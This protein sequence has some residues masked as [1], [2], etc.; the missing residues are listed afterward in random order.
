MKKTA[1]LTAYLFISLS[2]SATA[3]SPKRNV[4]KNSVLDYP[5]ILM[6]HPY[7]QLDSLTDSLWG[8]QVSTYAWKA[9]FQDN[10][11][12]YIVNALNR[13]QCKE[14]FV[15]PGNDQSPK[16]QDFL[17]MASSA[18]IAVARLLGENSYVEA[19]NGFPNLEA[20]ML[21]FKN[22]GFTAI[23][24]DIEPHALADYKQNIDLYTER[25][26]TLILLSSQWCAQEGIELSISIPM[27]TQ[28]STAALLALL[29]IKSYIM[30]Y[31]N[32]N[33]LS[34]L[35]RT[36]TLRDTLQGLYVWVVRAKDF[37]DLAHLQSAISVLNQNGVYELGIYDIKEM[38][39]R[40]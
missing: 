21:S 5:T 13:L 9:F 17:Q 6:E 23:H 4:A 36:A 3:T 32:P 38:D 22:A 20:K 15:S 39:V 1:I 33:M 19:D 34:L 10:T 27:H 37:T 29:Q 12:A 25:F 16:V 2:F 40:Y 35:N 24:L 26:N 8:S 7:R 30:A 28:S 14:V 31:E 18:N 11:N